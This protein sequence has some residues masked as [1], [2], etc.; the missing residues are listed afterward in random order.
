MDVLWG[1]APDPKPLRVTPV[2][3]SG[4]E[5]MGSKGGKEA[6]G[7]AASDGGDNN[8]KRPMARVA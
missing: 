2:A 1:G 7:A 4:E 8:D 3:A 6:A 5:K